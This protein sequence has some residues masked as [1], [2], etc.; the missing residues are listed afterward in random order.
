MRITPLGTAKSDSPC[1]AKHRT[2]ST[3]TTVTSSAATLTSVVASGTT[4]AS[5]SAEL[6]SIH[7]TKQWLYQLSLS[8]PLPTIN[9]ANT[10][11]VRSLPGPWF[12]RLVR[13]LKAKYWI[14]TLFIRLSGVSFAFLLFVD[15]LYFRPV[16]LALSVGAFFGFSNL[17]FFSSLDILALLLRSYEFWFMSALNLANW[18]T[19]ALIFR[20]ARSLVSATCWIGIQ[21]VMT[22]D[23]NYRSFKTATKSIIM[24][25]PSMTVLAVACSYQ[26]VGNANFFELPLF[27]FTLHAEHVI[28]YASST[29]SLFMLKKSYLKRTRHTTTIDGVHTIPCVVLKARLRLS[30][31]RLHRARRV[32]VATNVIGASGLSAASQR[33]ATETTSV[34]AEEPM[35]QPSCPEIQQ[36]RRSRYEETVIDARH[37]LIPVTVAVRIMYSRRLATAIFLVGCTGFTLSIYAV[38][39]VALFKPATYGRTLPSALLEAGVGRLTCSGLFL[40]ANLCLAQR[41][42]VHLLLHNFDFV[43]SSAQ[44]IALAVCLCDLMRWEPSYCLIVSAW[45]CW[46]HWILILDAITPSVKAR[47]R[48]RRRWAG[49]VILTVLLVLVLVAAVLVLDRGE[50]GVFVDHV[51]WSVPLSGEHVFEQRTREFALQR[52]VTILGWNTRLVLELVRLGD[53]SDELLFIQGLVEYTSAFDTFPS[54]AAAPHVVPEPVATD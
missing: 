26:L 49:L 15:S 38:V 3:A 9:L 19:L 54:Q 1:D 8:R 50:S 10:I 20:D 34:P 36:L 43:F 28:M 30:P 12:D 25:I 11:A 24:S 2:D 23:A 44:F 31:V 4:T 18:L 17:V 32:G 42:L 35:V 48:I 45:A 5:R 16:A 14:Q 39:C 47:L 33:E 40:L 22:I 51:I 37:M 29:L 6:A 7:N 52:I 27:S 53:D 46:F 13:F 41:D 21:N